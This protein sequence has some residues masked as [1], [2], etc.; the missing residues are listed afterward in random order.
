MG[1]FHT[2]D[3]HYFLTA[4]PVDSHHLV[5]AAQHHKWPIVRG[6]KRAPHSVVSYKHMRAAHM[7]G[8]R[9]RLTGRGS[10]ELLHDIAQPRRVV[11]GG[12]L[13]LRLAWHEELAG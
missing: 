7:Y 8:S 13:G 9:R 3:R 10:T 12:D 2:V 4:T 6:L 5:S 11:T 1:R